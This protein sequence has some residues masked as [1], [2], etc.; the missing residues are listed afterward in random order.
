MGV[1]IKKVFVY[2]A[3]GLGNQ[4]F[5]L[6]AGYSI[7]SGRELV[8]EVGF[9]GPRKDLHAR[10]VL[11]SLSLNG[12]VI[13]RKSNKHKIF[14]Q[15]LLDYLL[16]VST[17]TSG[18]ESAQIYRALISLAGSFYFSAYY[19]CLLTISLSKGVGYCA[20][21]KLKNNQM[22]IGYFQSHRYLEENKKESFLNILTLSKPGPQWLH[23]SQR[24]L[25]EKPVIVHIRL[26]DYLLEKRFG[27]VT[28]SYISESLS[29]LGVVPD[30][31][32]I[33]VF[34]DQKTLASSILP[35]IFSERAV[36]VPEIDSDPM[37]TLSI[38]R[39]GTGYVIA[40][41]S[42]SWWAAWS[43]KISESPVYCPHPWFSGSE[44]PKDLVP[45]Y[46]IQVETNLK[47]QK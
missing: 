17:K 6:A 29:R 31:R 43:R 26:G 32:P 39:L 30:D 45:E 11:E 47:D 19:K 46:W 10:S 28:S 22:I 41:S 36:W 42:F 44:T 34:T 25:D 15:T 2:A 14:T 38:M 16:R 40:N 21:P 24:A 27:I 8:C 9:S 12:L 18:L 5:Q 35:P 23:W 1:N 20:L 37:A 33:W 4:L 13:I 7:S 3:G